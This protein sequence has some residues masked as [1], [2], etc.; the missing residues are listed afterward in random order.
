MNAKRPPNQWM[1]YLHQYC[2]GCEYCFD[3]GRTGGGIYWIE[4]QRGTWI[5]LN[6]TQFKRELQQ[7]G[8]PP[9]VQQGSRAHVSP[10]DE[11]LLG[12]QHN[13]DVAFAGPL[14]GYKAG[15]HEMCGQR[16]LVTES[17]RIIEP[18]R[19]DWPT[20]RSVIDGMLRGEQDQKFNQEHYLYG[21][22]KHAREALCAGQPRPAQAVV[23]AGPHDCGKSLLQNLF[24]VLFGGRY[25]RPYKFMTGLTEFNSDLFRSEHLMIEDEPASTDIRSRRNFGAQIK[26]ITANEGK[27]CHAKHRVAVDLLPFWR[28][29]I[30]VND[31]PENLMVLPPIDDS[32]QDKL[33]I[34]R[35]VKKP[36]PMPTKTLKQRLVF[37]EKLVGE[38]PAFV[39]FLEEW[40]IPRKLEGDRYG[41]AYFH[42][43]EI[44]EAIDALA[45]EFKLL[46]LIKHHFDCLGDTSW[47]PHPAEKLERE[48]N[49]SDS[50]YEAK[51]L[52]SFPDA[53]GTYLGRLAK[54]YPERFISTRTSEERLWTIEW[55]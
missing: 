21:W 45:P 10:V 43:P 55:P 17:P 23:F 7:C 33:I 51:K 37:W 26:I 40:R 4:N 22:A 44:L 15:I 25:A 20:L 42:H 14:A 12:I 3:A 54:K 39:H 41:V 6:E 48:L 24:T 19:G 11:C 27:R 49:G 5:A 52:F 53:C 34:L 38:L 28:L 13:Y 16:I 1:K 47:G 2:P 35:T 32:I 30:S 31:E 8:V 36:M 18:R 9:K 29:S 46:S 50:Q